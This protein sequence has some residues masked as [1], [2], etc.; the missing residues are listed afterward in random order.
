[1]DL[2]VL[3]SQLQA[4][5]D[6]DLGEA[7]DVTSKAVFDKGQRADAIIVARENGVLCGSGVVVELFRILDEEVSVIFS[8]Q[9]GDCVDADETVA[10]LEGPIVSLLS[11]ERTALNYLQRLSGVAT[12]TARFVEAASG[13]V[14][15]CDTR[16]T[17][18]GWRELEKHAVACGGGVNHRMGLHDMVMLKDTH[19][20]ASGGVA[21]ALAKAAHL[22]PGLKIACEA[23]N[24]R[25]VREALAGGC[26][27]LM[28]DN[29]DDATIREAVRIA[30]GRVEV[31]V[32]GG[33]TLERLPELA[34]AGADRVSVGAL[35]HS[36]RALDFSL[37]I[38][39]RQSHSSRN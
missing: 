2:T 37:R 30:A 5:L 4:A 6:E 23:R 28:L 38:D 11:G 36:A 16:K 9:D 10:R 33:V 31:E 24:M 13:Q 15:V 27:L 22:K 14:S 12:L 17:T 35:T 7:G 21:A 39:L 34:A 1:M 19:A 18:P 29:M 25:E 20:D 8:R 32:T 3:H 26:D